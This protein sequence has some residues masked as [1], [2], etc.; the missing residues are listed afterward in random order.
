VGGAA[1]GLAVA[2]VV[3]HQHAVVL[4]TGGRVGRQQLDAASVDPLG[5]PR[6]LGEEP[7]Q[8]LHG[9]VLGADDRLRAGQGG[10]GLVAVARQ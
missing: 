2:A 10:Q 6:R 4:G 3:D 5:V 7:L 1:A 9:L 8:P